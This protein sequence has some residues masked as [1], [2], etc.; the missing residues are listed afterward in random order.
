LPV[1]YAVSVLVFKCACF[2]K[3]QSALAIVGGYVTS[4]ATNV[5]PLTGASIKDCN[6]FHAGLRVRIVTQ[7]ARATSN[8]FDN[9]TSR[10]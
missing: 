9:G 4:Y 1:V 7:T 3:L 2:F 10:Y 6:S 5:G 8:T